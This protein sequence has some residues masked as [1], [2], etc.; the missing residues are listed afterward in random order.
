MQIWAVAGGKGGTGK[1]L[2]AHG[3]GV[4][5]VEQ[6]AQVILVDADYGGPN[7]HI[8]CG[9]ARPAASLTDFFEK[10]VALE[11]LVLDTPTPG[12]RLIPGNINS[13]NAEGIT[14]AQKA[15]LF[16]HLRLLG[17]DHVILDLGA[18]SHY[19]TLDSFLMADRQIG[20]IMPDRLAIENFYLF[21]KN[22]KFRQLGN[23][24]SQVG[25]KVQAHDIWKDRA[26]Y[27][28]TTTKGFIRHLQALSGVFEE[29]LAYEQ[30]RA[31]LQVILNQVREYRQVELG[32]SVQS[33]VRKY[34][35]MDAAFAGFIRHDKDLWQAFGQDHAA[36]SP[37]HSV[38][39]HLALEGILAAIL[40][41]PAPAGAL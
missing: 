33:S 26:H 21:L 19:D 41:C 13:Q 34:F 4:G 8:Y 5:L 36:L 3:L 16:R 11:D 29:R 24:L 25:L 37:D 27:G 14:W 9:L 12:L 28:I 30:R 1:S 2:V 6:G 31:V 23:V 15:K 7:Q 20:V 10:K 40:A 38:T 39:V 18:G 22:L 35:D 17:A 32:L